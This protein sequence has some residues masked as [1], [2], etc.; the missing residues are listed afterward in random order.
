VK[1][2][3][4]FQTIAAA[5]VLFVSSATFS[6]ARD[7]EADFAAQH[8]HYRHVEGATD[9]P[10]CGGAWLGV[11]L[12]GR[13]IKRLAWQIE[14]SQRSIQRDYYFTGSGL[15]VVVE[16]VYWL[17]DQNGNHAKHPK[18][19]SKRRFWITDATASKKRDLIDHADYLIH[20]YRAHAHDFVP[21]KSET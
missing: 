4:Q 1:T 17:L 8:P 14:T 19:E 9:E 7:V 2:K 5:F 15:A 16:T 11:D 13:R 20:F 3:R 21:G 18:L 10:S 6:T 12:E